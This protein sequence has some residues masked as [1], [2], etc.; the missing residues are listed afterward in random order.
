MFVCVRAHIDNGTEQPICCFSEML[1]IFKVQANMAL[2]RFLFIIFYKSPHNLN[3]GQ[4]V[5]NKCYSL[6]EQEYDL[7]FN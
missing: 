3:N 1:C 2:H 5:L 7:F 4:R 6:F